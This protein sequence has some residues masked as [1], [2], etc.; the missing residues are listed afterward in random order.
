M[1]I[2][3]KAR[4]WAGAGTVEVICMRPPPCFA[5]IRRFVSPVIRAIIYPSPGLFFIFA[6]GLYIYRPLRYYDY[7]TGSFEPQV[8]SNELLRYFGLFFEFS[9]WISVIFKYFRRFSAFFIFGAA[10]RYYFRCEEDTIIIL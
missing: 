5:A 2:S 4:Y 8:K 10:R 9:I 7:I 1:W 6:Q 3:V